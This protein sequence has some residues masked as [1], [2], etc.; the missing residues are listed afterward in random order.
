[1]TQSPLRLAL[2]GLL[3]LNLCACREKAPTVIPALDAAGLPTVPVVP[4]GSSCGH[5]D[6][7]NGVVTGT[8][9][10]VL[11]AGEAASI[12]GW[13]MDVPK[14]ELATEVYVEI[15]GQ[16]YRAQYFEPRPDVG[17]MQGGKEPLN[18]AGFSATIAGGK[19]ARG[20]TVIRLHIVNHTRNGQYVGDP[21]PV[22]VH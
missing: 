14:R 5:I 15:A 4:G 17:K 1:M 13:A 11:Q 21:L 10:L 20:D 6:R 22:S 3:F 12:F 18:Y 7:V 16:G 2:A 9:P 8:V 19:I